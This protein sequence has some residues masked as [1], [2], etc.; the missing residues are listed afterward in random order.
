MTSRTTAGPQLFKTTDHDAAS[1]ARTANI[2]DHDG[3]H[4]EVDHAKQANKVSPRTSTELPG[5]EQVGRSPDVKHAAKINTTN[6]NSTAPP[7][8]STLGK[9]KKMNIN[10]SGLRLPPPFDS[11]LQSSAAQL[12]Q[13][14]KELDNGGIPELSDLI[15]ALSLDAEFDSFFTSLVDI[16]ETYFSAS[17]VSISIPN[18]QTDMIDVP[19]ALKAVWNKHVPISSAQKSREGSIDRSSRSELFRKSTSS[20]ATHNG[21]RDS[22]V[23]LRNGSESSILQYADEGEEESEGQWVDD[24]NFSNFADDEAVTATLSNPSSVSEPRIERPVSDSFCFTAHQPSYTL[25]SFSPP[26]FQHSEGTPGTTLEADIHGEQLESRSPPSYFKQKFSLTRKLSRSGLKRIP[27]LSRRSS[28]PQLNEK[29]QKPEKSPLAPTFTPKVLVDSPPPPLP[30]KDFPRARPRTRPVSTTHTKGRGST[31][32]RAF[33]S[34][35]NDVHSN[36]GSRPTSLYSPAQLSSHMKIFDRFSSL[37]YERDPLIDAQ[38][39]VHV[40]ENNKTIFLQRRYREQ[41]PDNSS[42]NDNFPDYIDS[43][44]AI[45]SPWA[46]SHAPSPAIIDHGEDFPFPHVR[47][48]QSEL[49]SAFDSS[50]ESSSDTDPASYS[51]AFSTPQPPV[52]AIGCENT[53]TILHIPLIVPNRTPFEESR[54]FQGYPELKFRGQAAPLAILSIMTPLIP[55]PQNLRKMLQKMTPH[56]A[57]VYMKSSLHSSLAAQLDSL[58]KTHS[59]CNSTMRRYGSSAQG[60]RSQAVPVSPEKRHS[61]ESQRSFEAYAPSSKKSTIRRH[62]R[63]RSR[64]ASMLQSHGASY[65]PEGDS[66]LNDSSSLTS[67]ISQSNP[68]LPNQ[69]SNYYHWRRSSHG[70]ERAVP[71]SRLLRTIIDAIPIQVFTMEPMSG[72]VTWVSNRTLAYQGKTAEEFF[73]NPHMAVHPDEREAFI[74][75][76]AES[77]RKGESLVRVA[78]V[79]R[80]D[81][82]Y[83]TASTRMVPL[84][85]NKGVITHWLCSMMDI[86]KQQEA[87]REALRRARETV[88]DQM[89]KILANATPIIVFTMHSKHGIVYANNMWFSYSGSS[90]EDTYGFEYLKSV[91][92]QDR[93]TCLSAL[94]NATG[95]GPYTAEI[96]LLDKNNDYNWHLLTFSQINLDSADERHLW[97]GT[98]TNI[99]NQKQIQEKL[100]EA[101]DAAQRTIESK[102]RFLSNMSHEIRT[103][104]I[105]ISGMVSFLL[106]TKLSDEQLDYCHTISSSSDA[107][108]MVINDILDL[109]KVESGKMTL[110]NSWFHVRR[111]VEEANEFL[112]S[113]AISKALELN[114]IVES[115]VPVWVRGDRIRLRQVLLNVIG[116]AIKFTDQGE[117]FTRCSVS[118]EKTDENWVMLKFESTDTGR[119]F[120]QEDEY[121][122]FKPFSQLKNMNSQTSSG[123][124]LGLVISR[125]LIQLHGGT[126]TC[127]GEKGKGSTFV[128]TCKVKLPTESDGPSPEDRNKA[129]NASTNEVSAVKNG[130]DL[131]I[132][133]ICPYKYAA[134]S[135]VHHICRTVADPERCRCTVAKDGSLLDLDEVEHTWTHVIINVVKVEEAVE[136]ANK[137]LALKPKPGHQI[138]VVLLSTPLQR[139]QIL[140]GIKPPNS[141][142]TILYKPLKPSR[143]SL[144]FDPSKEREASQDMKMQIAQK[145]LENQKDIF[146]SIGS[147]AKDKEHRVLLAEDNLVNQKVM[148]RFFAKSGLACDIAADGE[149]CVNRVFEKGAGYYDL[150]LVRFSLF[151]FF[152]EDFKTNSVV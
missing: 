27:S 65:I 96:R 75:A 47:S 62:L 125:Q 5:E 61:V 43:E 144:V 6:I 122:M 35:L 48:R 87:E 11:S 110:T 94:K 12:H 83:R 90:S 117:V 137:V 60:L 91:H 138:E 24:R 145:V 101:K 111:L 121:R 115:D 38:G 135:I 30:P 84:R 51:D 113:M 78:N 4:P 149:A 140:A 142:V 44:Q 22:S 114:Y 53:S 56:I 139:P 55:F 136:V 23:S 152:F 13:V 127:K 68:Q 79:R 89:Y 66:S 98:C 49:I 74:A 107:L 104:L 120:T 71:S 73:L 21:L 64:T 3:E 150:I 33:L 86:H 52:Y 54:N 88:S 85:D 32:S 26:R 10:S 133:I 76:W 95:P 124:G 28:K 36:V 25:P 151:F 146:K 148:S 37:D 112:S 131:N 17:R 99:Q 116:N 103:P 126:L 143:Y 63:T 92:P 108:L 147:F 16:L 15:L 141:K 57:A 46:V 7:S 31:D 93:E 100:Q 39:I 41:P 97:F 123:T 128:F 34:D 42:L 80:F 106:D 50:D 105:G 67:P 82:R 129:A 70:F 109:S 1:R 8:S 69:S 20:L 29:P 134:E 77:L 45:N 72:D 132:L 9:N 40:L 58:T 81:G 118:T 19:W 59:N 102:T 130:S 14:N 2:S 119:G 18:D